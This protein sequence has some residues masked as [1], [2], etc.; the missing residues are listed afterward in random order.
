MEDN[1]TLEEGARREI[2]EEAGIEG[3]LPLYPLESI[4]YLPDNIFSNEER[5]LWGRDVVVIPMYFF[6]MPFNGQIQL[7]DEHTGIK[8][9][10]YESAH[11]LIYYQDQKI[12]LYEL[13]EKL[14]RNLLQ[15]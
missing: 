1:E 11:E 4:S 14:Q 13:N 5:T 10:S 6:A 2:L 9:L 12:A 15:I 7:S 3:A 8:W